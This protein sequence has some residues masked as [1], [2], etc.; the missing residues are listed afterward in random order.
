MPSEE[1]QFKPGQSGNPKGRPKGS[2]NK[3][4]EA[5]LQALS[6]DFEVHGV[7]AIVA[8]RIDKPEAYLSTIGKLM[9]KLMELSGPDGEPVATVLNYKP[10]CKQPS[11]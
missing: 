10:V 4:S 5:F 2:R 8:V 6:D 3:L 1:T 7:D 9:P 11:K